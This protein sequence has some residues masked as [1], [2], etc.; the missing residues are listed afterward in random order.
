MSSR[1]YL[2][3][4]LGA[5]SGRVVAGLWNGAT[6]QL[7]ELHRFPNGGVWLGETLHW[8]VLRLWTE[9]QTGLAIAADRFGNSMHS[10]G[11]DTWGVDF[12][13]LSRSGEMLGWPYT[14]RDARTRGIMPRTF[15]K[16]PREQIFQSTGVQFMEINTL[17][18]L[19][20]LS[21]RNPEVLAAAD[22]F[23]MIPDFLNWC[24]SGERTGEFTNATTTQCF[25]AV[26]RTWCSALLDKLGIPKTIFPE[27]V[28]P[29]QQL[30]ALQ[31]A[32]A[33]RTGLGRVRV[34]APATHDTGSA[35]AAVPAKAGARPNWA[36]ISSGTWS[37]MGVEVRQ[38]VLT[39]R[40]LELN[41]TNEGGVDGT[42]RLLKNIMGLWLVQQCRRSFA[43]HQVD[44]DYF[45]LT[46][47]AE[48]AEPFRSL[49]DPDDARFLSPP[50][51]PAAIQEFCRE[52]NQPIPNS[53]GALIRCVLESLA[54]KYNAVLGWLEELT[55]ERIETIHIVGGGSR[56]GFLD[57]LTA[58]ACQRPIIAGPV[59]AT[60]LG[61][62]LMQARA[63]GDIASLEQMRQCVADSTQI[64]R[65]KPEPDQGRW[66]EARS[67][68]DQLLSKA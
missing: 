22:R 39:S 60:V 34:I 28:K 64:A 48:Q 36:Y 41:F 31:S 5:E 53:E 56:N 10:I 29:G 12:V 20:A 47:L 59:E 38:P 62:V 1:C 43:S 35:V 13:L 14:Y 54:L 17:Y 33:Q 15:Q 45:E 8:D 27:V 7:E 4:D 52:T 2:G 66:A 6:I 50:D 65:F 23:L 18:Q 32:V 55:G 3:I 11:V 25:G 61:N 51:M 30:G 44:L 37:L 24:L 19:V 63:A 26:E 57:Q 42:Y 9:I 21:E 58:N 46:A 68:F 40:A 49:I 16:V 67:R